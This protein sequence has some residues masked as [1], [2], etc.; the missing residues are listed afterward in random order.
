MRVPSN[1]VPATHGG[2][3]F[4]RALTVL[5]LIAALAFAPGGAAAPA[6]QTDLDAFMQQA[7]T[8]RDDNWK[9]LQQYVLEEREQMALTG[10]LH[11]PLWGERRE[12]T[13]FIRDGFFVRSPLKVDD[14]TI[15]A[16]ER[17]K[18]EDEYLKRRQKLEP[19]P[20]QPSP[21]EADAPTDVDAILRQARQPGFISS[22]YFLRVRFEEGKYALVGHDTFYGHDALRVEYYPTQLFRG[23]TR[24]PNRGD[25]SNAAEDEMRRMMNK[26]AL[27]TLWIEPASHQIVKYTFNNVALD[28]LPAQWLARVN[29]VRAT[30]TMAQAFPD[31]WLPQDLVVA[32][33]MTIAIGQYDFQYT[34]NY[35]DY[36]RADVTSKVG[37]PKAR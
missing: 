24:R 30:M 14:V 2:R 36:R 4:Q 7:L 18:Y 19:R 15:S 3:V 27:I 37:I 31:V 17:R 34:V 23:D 12:Y 11:R 21:A 13:W 20:A 8:T 22:A 25:R 28:F 33:S 32:A 16:A 26:V 1:T 29:D 5:C 10:P 35:H 6:S 9:K